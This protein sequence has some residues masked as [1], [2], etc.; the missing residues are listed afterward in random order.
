MKEIT[1]DLFDSDGHHMLALI[2]YN[3]SYYEDFTVLAAQIMIN[4]N[5]VRIDNTRMVEAQYAS[6][7]QEAIRRNK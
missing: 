5:G 1:I 2:R 3:E 6:D 4:G 7:I